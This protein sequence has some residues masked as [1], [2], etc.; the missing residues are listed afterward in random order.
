MKKRHKIVLASL[1]IAG[2]VA[3]AYSATKVP[4]PTDPVT[5]AGPALSA[6]VGP[7]DI[8]PNSAVTPGV[9][10][11][12]VTQDTISQNICNPQWSTKSIRPAASYTTQL[13]KQQLAG[14]YAYENITDTKLVE[15]DHLISLELGGNPTDP[16]NLWP[17]PY[18]ASIPNGGAKVK[19]SVENYL[20]K[21]V[22]SGAI[23]LTD[24]QHEIAT[25]W[26]AVYKSMGGSTNVGSLQAVDQNDQ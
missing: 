9:T 24:A 4:V 2:A 5:Q 6:Q 22:C 23:S 19:D 17:E 11:P 21:Q 18:S 3:T 13:K 26:Y 25:D 12:D 1:I 15:E 8:Y 7:A 20:H 16:K 14:D 10:N